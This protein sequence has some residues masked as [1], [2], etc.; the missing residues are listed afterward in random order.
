[1]KAAEDWLFALFEKFRASLLKECVIHAD[2]TTLQ[3]LRE[4]GRLA[5]QKSYM[6]LY[7]TSGCATRPLVLYE[8]QT[9]RS[10]AHPKKFLS[11]FS[12]YLHA[13]GYSGYHN[14][15]ETISVVGCWAHVRRKYDE[16]LTATP[17]NK[18]R[19]SLAEA[20][21]AMIN[22]LFML[23][24]DFADMDAD[25]RLVAR[26]E[27]SVSVAKRLHAWALTAGAVPKSLIGKAIHYTLEQWPYLMRVFEDGRCELSNN[28]AERS[29]KPFVI[30]RKNWLFSNTPKGAKAS[31]T[32]FSVIETAKENGLRPYEYLRYLFEQLPNITTSQIDAL[33]PWSESLPEYVKVPK[34]SQTH[35]PSAP[36]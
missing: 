2:E 31:A 22:E 27:K 32:V 26:Q 19:G 35:T 16:A 33:L 9:S 12:G 23:E 8:Y 11:G 29:I 30:G 5:K 24:R 10:H 36:V 18:R 7:R 20:G 4:N 17:E 25:G 28:R 13:D 15:P 3:V 14:L 6:W 1:M 34:A 21:L